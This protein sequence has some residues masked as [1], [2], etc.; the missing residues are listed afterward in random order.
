MIYKKQYPLLVLLLLF[1]ASPSISFSENPII[2]IDTSGVQD[3]INDTNCPLLIIASAAWCA[4]C[5]EELPVL[6]RLYLKYRDQGL[7]VSALSLDLSQSDMQ[8]LVD[9]MDLKFTVYWGGDAMASQYNIFGMPT[10][11]IVKDGKIQERIVG[12]RSEDFLE[13]TI[14]RLMESCKP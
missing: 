5:R 12:Q 2:P 9:Q 7:Q 8:R 4:P 1:L 10:I 3:L 11:L 13:K 6:N 14:S